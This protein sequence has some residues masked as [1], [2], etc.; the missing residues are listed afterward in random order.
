[1]SYLYPPTVSWSLNLF[2]F[3][4]RFYCPFICTV[5]FTLWV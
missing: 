2:T 1:V 4:L 5:N 3:T